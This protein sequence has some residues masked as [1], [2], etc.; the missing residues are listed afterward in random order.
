MDIF[1]IPLLLFFTLPVVLSLWIASRTSERDDY[2]SKDEW[3]WS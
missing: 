3:R 2:P 1:T